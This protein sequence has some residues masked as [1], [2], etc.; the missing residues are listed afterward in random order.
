MEEE[1]AF[2]LH[3]AVFTR[4]MILIEY[5]LERKPLQFYDV[6]DSRGNTPLLLSIK[7]GFAEIAKLLIERGSTV[8]VESEGSYSVLDEALLSC[9]D[10]TVVKG[11]K[12]IKDILTSNVFQ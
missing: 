7:L 9:R 2:H 8:E 10:Y 4:N 11:E 3:H 1:E 6:V 12:T 5:L